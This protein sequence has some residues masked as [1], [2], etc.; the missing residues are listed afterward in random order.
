MVIQLSEQQRKLNTLLNTTNDQK[1]REE[2]RQQ[3]NRKLN[4]IHEQ[5]A[6]E[7]HQKILEQIQEIEKSQEDS[8]RMFKAI[9]ILKSTEKKKPLLIQG[10]EGVTTNETDQVKIVAQHFKKMLTPDK[11]TEIEEIPP[12]EMEPSFTEDEVIKAIKKLKN[13]K[14]AGIDNIRA[15]QLKYGGETVPSKIANIFNEISKTGKCPTEIKQGILTPLQKPGKLAGPPSNLRPIILLSTIRKILAICLLNRIGKKIDAQI[16]VEQAAYRA[17]RGTTEHTFAFKLLAEKAIT[18]PNYHLHI[19]LMDMSKAFD[20]V[21]RN[22]LL[23]DLRQILTPA[24]LHIIKILIQ[25]IKLKVRIGKETSD[26]F[27]TKMGVPQGDCLS[28][29]LFTLYL[30]KA[31]KETNTSQNRD[32][33]YHQSNTDKK[34]TTYQ[35]GCKITHTP[36]KRTLD[37]S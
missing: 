22:T 14:S 36:N 3:R 18:T 25:D 20:T 33:T 7:K 13:N 10:E 11:E 1:K 24:E 27:T 26:D 16:P 4:K 15:E 6:E 37:S 32:H 29:I 34:M 19:T 21:Q 35:H 8:Y 5:L 17:G 9:K 12:T 30:A 31:L 23:K 2:I 28:P